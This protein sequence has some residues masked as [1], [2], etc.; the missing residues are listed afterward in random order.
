LAPCPF[1][2]FFSSSSVSFRFV[3]FFSLLSSKFHSLFH[4]IISRQTRMSTLTFF[5]FIRRGF[6]SPKC[7]V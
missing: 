3:P 1:S 5:P 6:D 7:V 2:F 4:Q